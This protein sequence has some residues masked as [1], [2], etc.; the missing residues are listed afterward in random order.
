MQKYLSTFKEDTPAWLREYRSGDFVPFSDFMSGRV[1]Y[2]PGSGYDGHLVSVANKAQCVHCFLYVD[3]DVTRKNLEKEIIQDGFRGYH[4]IGTVEWTQS[5]L[6]PNG[7]HALNVDYKPRTDPMH[8]INEEE[9]PYCFMNVFERDADKGPDWGAKRFA[10]TFLF[11]DGIATYYQLFC[12]EYKKAPWIMLLQDHGFGG[13]YDSFG[14]GGLLDAIITKNGIRPE[15]VLCADNTRIWDGY[16]AVEGAGATS[17]GMHNHI[18][19][20]FEIG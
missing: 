11:A 15:Y 8:F 2:Y 7:Q 9:Q 5:D 14:H 3:Y 6:M 16:A 17:G 19:Q 1:G 18:R 10:V 13:N 4:P 12:K 20:L